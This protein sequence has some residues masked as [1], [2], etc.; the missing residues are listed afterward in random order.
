MRVGRASEIDS[1]VIAIVAR[2][3]PTLETSIAPGIIGAIDA[4]KSGSTI[5]Q[6]GVT[7]WNAVDAVT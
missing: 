1:S 3:R 2:S 6:L 5:H 4:K 7:P